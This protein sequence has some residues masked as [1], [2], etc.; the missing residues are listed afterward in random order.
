MYQ[1]IAKGSQFTHFLGYWHVLE[2]AGSI[3]YN[4][5]NLNVSAWV[6]APFRR[7]QHQR[8]TRSLQSLQGT[9]KGSPIFTDAHQGSWNM[10]PG[11]RMH[12]YFGEILQNCKYHTFVARKWFP[13]NGWHLMSA[14]LCKNQREIV[15]RCLSM[16]TNDADSVSLFLST[17][18]I[19]SQ[20]QSCRSRPWSIY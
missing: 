20:I 3:L 9:R 18:Q 14:G 12:H 16:S 6:G 15:V 5:K 1:M 10:T 17:V 11:P 7:R 19:K 8:K 13:Q 4:G 2:G